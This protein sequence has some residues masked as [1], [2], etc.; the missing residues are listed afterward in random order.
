MTTN[1][2]TICKN[3]FMRAAIDRLLD[4]KMSYAG[5]ARYASESNYPVDP[6]MVSRHAEHYAPPP[7]KPLKTPK[8]DFAIVIRDKALEMVDT[9]SLALDNKNLVPGIQAGL[10][11]QSIL[12]QREKQKTKQQSAELAYAI[13]EM[14]GGGRPQVPQIEDGLTI[15]GDYEEVDGEAD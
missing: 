14:L 12:D 11:A 5:I 7:E 10:K 1:R 4:D 15:E 8:R 3:P 9:G 13:I 2:C 6:K